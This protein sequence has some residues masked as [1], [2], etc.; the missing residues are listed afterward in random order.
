MRLAVGGQY[1]QPRLTRQATFRGIPEQRPPAGTQDMGGIT[2]RALKPNSV[3]DEAATKAVASEALQ[4]SAG[5]Q[6]DHRGRHKIISHGYRNGR[7][8][9]CTQELNLLETEGFDYGCSRH[10][11][12]GADAAFF[13][14]PYI[15]NFC[16]RVIPGTKET[17]L[18]C[19]I[20]LL[21]WCPRGF[22]PSP[23]PIPVSKAPML[24]TIMLD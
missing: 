20:I 17:I 12:P 4:C 14:D 21:H 13:S 7:Q 3:I 24:I 1:Q 11:G 2:A 9:G 15:L 16:G 19:V 10:T 6:T 23:L 18:L 22:G 5:K 8:A